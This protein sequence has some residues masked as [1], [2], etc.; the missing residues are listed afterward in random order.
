MDDIHKYDTAMKKVVEIQGDLVTPQ[1]A[2]KIEDM[3]MI[4]CV[5]YGDICKTSDNNNDKQQHDQVL[6]VYETIQ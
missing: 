4:N 2:R 6:G 1:P 3:D 5:A